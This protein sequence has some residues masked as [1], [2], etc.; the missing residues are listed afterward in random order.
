MAKGLNKCMF[1]GNVCAD[2][3]SRFL[4]NGDAVA[5]L[6]LA[7]NDDY[8]DKQGNKVEQCEFV[9][10]VAF[11]RL[12]E[13]IGEYVTKGKKIYIEGKQR[14]RKWQDQNGQDRWTTEIV[15]SD[16]L[17]IDG[18]RSDDSAPQ[19]ANAASLEAQR[20]AQRA[21]AGCDFTDDIPFTRVMNCHAI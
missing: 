13:I 16:M 15:A 1:I 20:P 3:E 19:D 2:P 6:S 21:P 5:T 11:R 17:L 9:R 4:P 12:A 10:V 18:N 14:T 8:K 7:V